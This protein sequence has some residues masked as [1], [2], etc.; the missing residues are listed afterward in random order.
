MPVNSHQKFPYVSL[1]KTGSH[2]HPSDQSLS[3]E[4]HGLTEVTQ[5]WFSLSLGT[6]LVTQT[7]S[8]FGVSQDEGR[9]AV[10]E[11]TWTE[12]WV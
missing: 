6:S 7:K 10:R 3:R 12:E 9:M 1:A 4:Q 2:T 8:G 5:S 11:A